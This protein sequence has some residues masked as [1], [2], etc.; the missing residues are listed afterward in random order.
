V[1]TIKDNAQSFVFENI[2]SAPTP[3]WLRE[4]SAPIKLAC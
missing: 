2:K 3:S 1:L 4:F